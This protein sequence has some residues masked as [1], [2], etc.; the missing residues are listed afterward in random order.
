MIDKIKSKKL[1]KS[2]L[3]KDPLKWEGKDKKVRK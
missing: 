2:K 1:E 3:N